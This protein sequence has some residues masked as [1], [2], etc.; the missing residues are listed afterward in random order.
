MAFPL[1]FISVII[2]QPADV[3]PVIEPWVQPMLDSLHHGIDYANDLQPKDGAV[4]QWF[5]AHSARFATR[6]ELLAQG[7]PISRTA[8]NAAIQFTFDGIH[9]ARLV[10][11]L[12]DDTPHP[13]RNRRRQAAWVGIGI[14]GQFAFPSAKGTLPPLSLLFD[15]QE[16]GDEPVVHC[17]LPVG[18][19]RFMQRARLHWRVPLLGGS[20][21]ANLRFD[22]PD[23]GGEPQIVID[24]ADVE[25]AQ[26]E[27]G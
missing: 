21:L 17:S 27:S 9:H 6:R 4:E 1:I 18:S 16:R 22:A 23:D 20:A 14:Q 15:W 26:P 7:A 3:L 12:W 13:G 11:S 19:W 8:P 5:W 24:A 10:R 2:P 25:I